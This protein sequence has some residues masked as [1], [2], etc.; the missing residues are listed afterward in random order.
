[1]NSQKTR[2]IIETGV[3]IALSVVLSMIK[4]PMPYGGSI[5]VVSMLPVIFIAYKYGIAWG[6]LTGFAYGIMQLLV[7]SGSAF[8]GMTPWALIACIAFDYILAFT[9]FGLAG[10]MKGKLKK[11]GLGLGVGVIIAGVLRYIMH[12][13][14]GLILFGDYAEWFFTD[15]MPMPSILENYSGLALSTIYS[16]I[17]NACYMLP[18]IAITLAVAIGAGALINKLEGKFFPDK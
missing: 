11:S 5:T 6:T 18:E 3:L 15:V 1:M 14:S 13:I 17:Y 4:F 10:L 7:S 9:V 2:K 16:V 12:T 8:K